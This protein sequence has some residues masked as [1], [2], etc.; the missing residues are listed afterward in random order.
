MAETLSK[1][2]Q[3]TWRHNENNGDI[4]VS[5]AVLFHRIENYAREITIHRKHYQMDMIHHVFQIASAAKHIVLRV[6]GVSQIIERFE[7]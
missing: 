3:R 6:E 5:E 2:D 1:K 4:D 7:T